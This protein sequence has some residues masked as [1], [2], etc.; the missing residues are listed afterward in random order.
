[1]V[2]GLK[3]DAQVENGDK[4]ADGDVSDDGVTED[5]GDEPWF[6]MRMIKEEKYETRRPLSQ[7]LI[8]KLVER[9]IG[10]QFLLRRL[11]ALWRIQ[12]QFNLIDL[13]N[14]YYIV[15]FSQK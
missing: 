14:D 2:M 3:Q 8:I 10:Y 13:S 4:V 6:S 12:H 15:K 11:I 1:M 5:D 7:S 9:S